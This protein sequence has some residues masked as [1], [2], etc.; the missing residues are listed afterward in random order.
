MVTDNYQGGS[1]T[2]SI[3]VFP[4][5]WSTGLQHTL[6]GATV[7]FVGYRSDGWVPAHLSHF[8]LDSTNRLAISNRKKRRK[9][10]MSNDGRQGIAMLV[11]QP[12]AENAS[13]LDPGGGI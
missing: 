10:W 3:L 9:G 5:R 8:K 7:T 2:N 12:V 6:D 1:E 11:G 4:W 13:W